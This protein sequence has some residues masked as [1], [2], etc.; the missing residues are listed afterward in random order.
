MIDQ[1][2]DYMSARVNYD[3]VIVPGSASTLTCRISSQINAQYANAT[4]QPGFRLV[5]PDKQREREKRAAVAS[6]GSPADK[7]M[8]KKN[9]AEILKQ[10]FPA[11]EDRTEDQIITDDDQ[12]GS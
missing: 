9:A 8:N 4:Y 1:P 10:A 12:E 6:P 2:R 7:R 5:T 11:A 3:A